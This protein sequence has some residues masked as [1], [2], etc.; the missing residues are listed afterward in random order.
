MAFVGF[1]TPKLAT[2]GSAGSGR[3]ARRRRAWGR[4]PT[5]LKSSGR[6]SRRARPAANSD[7]VRN[8]REVPTSSPAMGSG[9]EFRVAGAMSLQDQQIAEVAIRSYTLLWSALERQH[10]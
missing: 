4:T 8:V 10:A 7:V 3:S 2:T 5:R 1:T 9:R 6:A